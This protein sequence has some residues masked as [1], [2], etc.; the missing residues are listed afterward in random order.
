[1]ITIIAPENRTRLP[2]AVADPEPTTPDATARDAT[3][4]TPARASTSSRSSN[5]RSLLT[6]AV[7][8]LACGCLGAWAYE[9]YAAKPTVIGPE[10]ADQ[11]ADRPAP[12]L[13]TLE[14]RMARIQGP[15]AAIP[16]GPSL[17]DLETLRRQV[18]RLDARLGT[19]DK[20]LAA[21]R[22]E[23]AS[24][25]VLEAKAASSAVV[26]AS[27]RGTAHDVQGD[28]NVQD[29]AMSWGTEL[30][31]RGKYADALEFFQKLQA[32][33]PDDAR[34]WYFSALAQGFTDRDWRGQAARFVE[35]GIACEQAG[36]PGNYRID[37]AFRSLTVANGRD[38]LAVYR[39]RVR[40]GRDSADV[41]GAV[42]AVTPVRRGP[43]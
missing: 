32:N 6:T 19:V 35:K 29:A 24:L 2:R 39:R 38:W 18:A 8:S 3:A 17:A 20:T 5:R 36:T 1:M 42:P 37:I 13:D 40:R 14:D 43:G 34:V 25:P 41:P 22:A 21:L 27:A 28:G 23:V 7:L 12:A 30:F 26:M 9:T 33:H 10:P 16:E 15:V 4:S 31:E 11:S